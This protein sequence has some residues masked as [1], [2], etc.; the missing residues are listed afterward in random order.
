MKILFPLMIYYS[1]SSLLNSKL[2]AMLINF[3]SLSFA[4]R[5]PSLKLAMIERE[6]IYCIDVIELNAPRRYVETLPILEQIEIENLDLL[7][8]AT[9]ATAGG[10]G[11]VQS[12][13]HENL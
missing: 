13:A 11:T 5:P 3:P 7:C 1:I 8:P 12:R 4:I 2:F 6:T 10:R 9:M